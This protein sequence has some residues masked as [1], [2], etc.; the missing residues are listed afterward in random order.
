MANSLSRDI[1]EGEV[2]VIRA[3]RVKPGLSLAARLFVVAGDGFGN[4]ARTMGTALFGRWLDGAGKDRMDGFDID[5]HLTARL[6]NAYGPTPT[7]EQ[8]Q[9]LVTG[10]NIPHRG[11]PN[12]TPDS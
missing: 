5:P 11:K 2:V 7:W 10:R 8:V 4:D 1:K 3:K 12:P 6:Q 9:H